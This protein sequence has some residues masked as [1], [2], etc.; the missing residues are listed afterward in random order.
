MTVE[1]ERLEGASLPLGATWIEAEQA[2]NFAIYSKH[3]DAVTLLLYDEHEFA[4]P[5]RSVEFAFPSNKTNR[6]WHLRLAA[7]AAGAAR[8]YAYRIEGPFDPGQ[9]Q[10]FDG[11]KIL[12][13]PYATSVFFPPGFSRAAACRPGSNA[14]QGAAWGAAATAAGR[15]P[16]ASAGSAL[17]PRP[18]HLRDA[19][20][21]LHAARQ[22]RRARQPRAAPSPASSR[23]F[24][25]CGSSASPR[26]NCCRC[27]SSIRWK[28][29]TGAT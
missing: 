2:Y 11:E 8:Y 26:W 20:A 16:A 1:W 6:V 24:P 4:T 9:G 12:L 23:K 21:R 13:D 25:I 5:L 14:G 22:F 28:A 15:R 19:R 10:R 27:S 7:A 18:G 29:T 3:A 17:W